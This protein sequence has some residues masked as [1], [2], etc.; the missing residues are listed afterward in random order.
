M[1][2]IS[3]LTQTTR[4]VGQEIRHHLLAKEIDVA[5]ACNPLLIAMIPQG[6]RSL[7]VDCPAIHHP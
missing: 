5:A 3:S 2:S 7:A 4:I 6:L 1:V